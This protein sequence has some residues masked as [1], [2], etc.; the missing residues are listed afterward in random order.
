MSAIKTQSLVTNTT[1]ISHFEP[2]T[3]T[4]LQLFGAYLVAGVKY[5]HTELPKRGKDAWLAKLPKVDNSPIAMD[6]DI[7]CILYNHT[8]KPLDIIWYGKLRNNSE[9]VR[10]GGDALIG[11]KSFEETLINQEEIRVRA[12]DLDDNIHHAAF[13]ITSYHNQPLRFAKKGIAT[14]T[15]NENNIAHSFHLDAIEGDCQ[16]FLAW[17]I[18]RTDNDW[19][20]HAPMKNLSTKDIDSLGDA[21]STLLEQHTRW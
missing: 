7:V 21:V 3:L 5:E 8:R 15:D 6:I 16:S 9:T 2:R 12:L 4:Q 17:H 1:L 13:V 10:H 18:Q 20:V 14:L 11:S 19:L